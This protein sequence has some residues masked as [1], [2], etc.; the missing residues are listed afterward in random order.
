[1]AGNSVE[2]C[3]AVWIVIQNVLLT[4]KPDMYFFCLEHHY[5]DSFALLNIFAYPSNKRIIYGPELNL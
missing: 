2:K 3:F 1:M 5:Q 4:L